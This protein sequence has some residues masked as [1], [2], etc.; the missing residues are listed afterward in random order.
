[1]TVNPTSS[2]PIIIPGDAAYQPGTYT[3]ALG[4]DAQK[5]IYE[6]LLNQGREAIF[7]N[8][9]GDVISGFGD[10]LSSIYDTV[11]N[12]SCLSSGDKSSLLSAIG[13]GGVGGL[14]E[15]LDLFRTHT[16]ILSGVIAQGTNSTPGLDRILSVGKSLGNLS[17]A[18]D[19][20]SD[21]FSLLNNMTG[22]FSN[23]LIN[24]YAGEIAGMIEQI[25]NCLADVTSIISR[26]N[27]MV[28]TLQ[29]IINADNNFF[30]NALEQ[31]RQAALSS[32][33]ESMY[34]NPCGKFLLESKI[35]Q[36]KLLGYLR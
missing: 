17:Y 1:M 3:G 24:G 2:S 13:T 21:C 11:T 34:S 18:I 26:I 6:T 4:S 15:Q 14:S 25:N 12:S 32:L 20:A 22:L 16:D 28:A 9:V 19:G 33:L 27:E 5:G 23:D 10:N 30:D 31:L 29:N 36:S 7:Q 35:G 8:P